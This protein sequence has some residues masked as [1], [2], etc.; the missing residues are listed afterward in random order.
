MDAATV[1]TKRTAGVRLAIFI[2]Q[3]PERRSDKYWGAE[4]SKLYKYLSTFVNIVDEST[5]G[6]VRRE[7]VLEM[8]T[9]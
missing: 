2:R 6:P 8:Q 4:P 5:E 3:P 7:C 9:C 1:R